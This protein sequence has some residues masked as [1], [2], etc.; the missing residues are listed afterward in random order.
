MLVWFEIIKMLFYHVITTFIQ[1]TIITNKIEIL[2]VFYWVAYHANGML[3][4]CFICKN[5]VV[6]TLLQRPYN[7]REP[8]T[9]SRY[10]LNFSELLIILLVCL[11]FVSF[12]KNSSFLRYYNVHTTYEYHKQN[13]DTIRILVSCLSY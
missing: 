9:K 7:V 3:T 1:R 11:H 12:V 10:Y 5:F 8:R 13:R 4:F 6:F 2:L